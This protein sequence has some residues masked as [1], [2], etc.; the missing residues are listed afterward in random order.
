MRRRPNTVGGGARTNVNGLSFEGRTDL[1]E[2]LENNPNFKVKGN[3][4]FQNDKLVGEYFE[5]HNLFS[6]LKKQAY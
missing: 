6:V 3:E 4:V 1:L 5:K 2:S